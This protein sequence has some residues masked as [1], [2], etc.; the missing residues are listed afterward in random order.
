MTISWNNP[1][2]GT[3]YSRR[4]VLRAKVA[5]FISSI[6]DVAQVP[7]ILWGEQAV[8]LFTEEEHLATE[9]RTIEF[10]VPDDLLDTAVRELDSFDQHQLC[11]DPGCIL[12][13]P[14][15]H[16]PVPDAHFHTPFL[17]NLPTLGW[18]TYEKTSMRSVIGIDTI[19]LFIKSKTLW[20]LPDSFLD[21][22]AECSLVMNVN[23]HH[24][25]SVD[26]QNLYPVKILQPM[27]LAEALIFLL[28]R[29]HCQVDSG[30]LYWRKLIPAM[31]K[32]FVGNERSQ[33]TCPDIQ[34]H[35]SALHDTIHG[36]DDPM[37]PIRETRE[38]LIETL[39]MPAVGFN[40][41]GPSLYCDRELVDLDWLKAWGEEYDMMG[42]PLTDEDIGMKRSLLKSFMR[43]SSK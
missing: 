24:S 27:A 3:W 4:Q 6:L 35:W 33:T 39:E 43:Y 21:F 25:W 42:I 38:E 16:H 34:A 13:Q 28:G 18:L 31:A 23:D 10:V 19:S 29:D 7:N 5:G 15:Q 9:A 2:D 36:V 17:H 1:P 32:Q 14:N 22:S 11:V 20:W 12:I 41:S 40:P 37:S 30:I 26:W 8:D